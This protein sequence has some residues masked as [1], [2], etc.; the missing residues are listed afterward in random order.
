MTRLLL[1]RHGQSVWNA[2]G[3]WQGQ[4]DPPLSELGERQA[5]AA[6]SA[7][8]PVDAVVTSDLVRASRTAEILGD[9]LGV[10][11]EVERGFRERDAGEWSG[12]T[13]VEIEEAWPGYLADHR[14]PP[15]FELDEPLVERVLEAIERT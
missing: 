13:R 5:E 6:G 9:S 15:G 11:V 1:V 10:P 12:L 7:I 4:A 2:E 3:R 14:R 8:E